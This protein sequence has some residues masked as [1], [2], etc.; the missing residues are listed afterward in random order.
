MDHHPSSTHSRPFTRKK[1]PRRTGMALVLS[2]VVLLLVTIFMTEF[3]FETTLEIRTIENFQS[4]FVARSVVKSMFRAV[5]AALSFNESIFFEQ[6]AYI[7]Q[8][9][10]AHEEYSFLDPPN[11]LFPLPE[12]ILPVLTGRDFKGAIF[13]TPYVRPIDHLFNL[14]R[15][16]TEKGTRAPDSPQDR[17]IFN[18]FVNLVTQIPIEIPQAEGATAPPGFYYLELDE[19]A[20]L[21]AAIFDWTD[22][23]DNGTPYYNEAGVVGVEDPAYLNFEAAPD[24]KI[25]NRGFDRLSELKLV[26]GVVESEI[27]FEDWKRHFTVHEVGIAQG[28]EVEPRLN[29]NL[30]T[31]NEIDVFLRRFEQN[32][33]YYAELGGPPE[34]R[35]HLQ[36]FAEFSQEI[37][38]ALVIHD[39]AGTHVRFP[40]FKSI[41]EV[42]RPLDLTQHNYQDF[43]ILHS[44]WYE[45]RLVAEMIG[46]QAEIQAIVYVPRDQNGDVNGPVLIKDFLLR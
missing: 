32:T 36:E 29:V 23:R 35:E 14:N 30:A 44:N 18:Q 9:S 16:Q 41:N 15:L 40:D 6:L 38:A 5:L 11:E 33:Q 39:N 43:F 19:I 13:F 37:A 22:A 45:I 21:Y 20:P 34:N 27:P 42:L 25:K 31:R 17:I 3:L 26:A 1:L 10:G 12:G 24:L 28:L 2:L 46:I 8:L 7:Y 4:S